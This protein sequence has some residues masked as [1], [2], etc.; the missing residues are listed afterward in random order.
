[1]CLCLTFRQGDWPSRCQEHAFDMDVWST[2][3]IVIIIVIRSP[4]SLSLSLS[5]SLSPPPRR[6]SDCLSVPLS[7]HSLSPVCLFVC[8]MTYTCALKICLLAWRFTELSVCL[9]VRKR[10]HAHLQSV[11]LPGGSLYC[12]F[13]C[14]LVRP[15][16][17]LSAC[18]T[19]HASVSLSACLYANVRAHTYE[20]FAC[21]TVR[22]AVC[23]PVCLSVPQL[24]SQLVLLSMHPSVIHL[25]ATSSFCLPVSLYFS[26]HLSVRPVCLSVCFFCLNSLPHEIRQIQSATAFKTALKTHLF[27]FYLC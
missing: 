15:L 24:V 11:C 16:A 20:L 21:L 1:M 7:V 14:L 25:S 27:K 3:Q 26:T 9:S 12:L 4:A 5:L 22:F 6:L 2:L 19:V 23:L 17:C 13:A 10:S 18:P 8:T